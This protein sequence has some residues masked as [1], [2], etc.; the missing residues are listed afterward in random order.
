MQEGGESSSIDL[1]E[2]AATQPHV[3]GPEYQRRDGAET[4]RQ[5]VA[6]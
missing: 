3:P 6:N 4:E 2:L 1:R 5:V